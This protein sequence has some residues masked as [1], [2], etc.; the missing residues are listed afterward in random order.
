M[1]VQK[2]AENRRI[3]ERIWGKNL[4]FWESAELF[5][6]STEPENPSDCKRAFWGYF[7]LGEK[8][9]LS[10]RLGTLSRFHLL[11][12]NKFESIYIHI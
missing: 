6:S 8:I 10:T 12:R 1:P 11:P 4:Q 2:S 9:R 3:E 7:L 5:P